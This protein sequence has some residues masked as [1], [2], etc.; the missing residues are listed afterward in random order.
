MPE[1]DKYILAYRSQHYY[2]CDFAILK[3]FIKHY[4]L[5]GFIFSVGKGFDLRNRQY[6]LSF[7]F[8]TFGEIKV[9][10]FSVR[11]WTQS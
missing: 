7:F 6:Y 3:M 11:R 5:N 10:T 9:V 2:T 1:C 8:E 4:Y